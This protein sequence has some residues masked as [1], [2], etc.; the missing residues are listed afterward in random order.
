MAQF[1]FLHRIPN[2]AMNH[3]NIVKHTIK[4]RDCKTKYNSGRMSPSCKS[5]DIANFLRKGNN[6]LLMK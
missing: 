3:K 4:S 1:S 2:L 5:G 6:P